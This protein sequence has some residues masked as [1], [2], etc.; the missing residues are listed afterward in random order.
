MTATTDRPATL[1]HRDAQAIARAVILD[2]LH[3]HTA[4]EEH[5][6]VWTLVYKDG[7]RASREWLQARFIRDG[8]QV[9]A[10]DIGTGQ[11]IQLTVMVSGV[12]L[13]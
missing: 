11:R 1:D 6:R 4:T 2:A 9:T 12:V 3:E 13:P 8:Y 10:E 5:G 7:A